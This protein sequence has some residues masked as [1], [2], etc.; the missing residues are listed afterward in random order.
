MTYR[1]IGNITCPFGFHQSQ[2]VQIKIRSTFFIKI[3]KSYMQ[4][5][6]EKI[7]AK[8]NVKICGFSTLTSKLQKSQ[9]SRI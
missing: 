3:I 5:T 4:K 8:K 1:R 9:N 2:P 6:T 7:N